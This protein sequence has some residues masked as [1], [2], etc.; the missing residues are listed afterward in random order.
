MS[1]Y[2]KYDFD[3][4]YLRRGAYYPKLFVDV[5]EEQHAVRRR[6]L[7]VLDGNRRLPV[8]VFE[9]R[10]PDLADSPPDD[11]KKPL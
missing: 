6:V 9:Q 3:E 8:G 2:F 4:V 5:E 1:K 11:G 10:F 7:E